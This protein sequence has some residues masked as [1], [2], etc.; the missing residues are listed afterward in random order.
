MAKIAAKKYAFRGRHVTNL[1]AYQ[2]WQETLGQ[3]LL[4]PFKLDKKNQY[5]AQDDAI[6]KAI[7]AMYPDLGLSERKFLVP[8]T[9]RPREHIIGSTLLSPAV[10]EAT[11][12]RKTPSSSYTLSPLTLE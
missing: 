8:R 3:A 10:P 6:V 4:N 12:P 5:L 7:I 11:T 9:D 1:N 2:L